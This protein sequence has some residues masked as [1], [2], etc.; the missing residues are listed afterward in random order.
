MA[1]VIYIL[2][3]NITW[4]LVPLHLMAA[5][6]NF[7]V[8]H[9]ERGTIISKFGLKKKQIQV[10]RGTQ[11]ESLLVESFRYSSPHRA[12]SS[13]VILGSIVPRTWGGQPNPTLGYVMFQ[14]N[15]WD[16]LDSAIYGWNPYG[17]TMFS[18][19]Y[20]IDINLIDFPGRICRWPAHRKLSFINFV[21]I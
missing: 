17:S 11:S 3:K 2:F 5:C 14:Q 21:A 12:N 20:I 13:H 19:V 6:A 1:N 18:F 4:A 15:S 16:V 7:E 8:Q 9:W 10:L